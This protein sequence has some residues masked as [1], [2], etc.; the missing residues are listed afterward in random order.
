MIS[1]GYI[2][3]LFDPGITRIMLIGGI[4]GII[5]GFYVMKRISAIEV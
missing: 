4:M 5:S 2:I 1:P 3:K